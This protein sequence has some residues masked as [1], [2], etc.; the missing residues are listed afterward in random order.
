MGWAKFF[1]FVHA[2]NG[3]RGR[4]YAGHASG[5]REQLIECMAYVMRLAASVLAA[6]LQCQTS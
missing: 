5:R 6:L 4:V 1:V 2:A 3:P